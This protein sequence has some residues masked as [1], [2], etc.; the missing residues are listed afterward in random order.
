MHLAFGFVSFSV[1]KCNTAERIISMWN[2][3]GNILLH[4]DDVGTS[5]PTIFSLPGDQFAYGAYNR[6][7]EKGVKDGR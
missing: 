7:P 1:L 5:K 2:H 4:R 6:Q 3:T